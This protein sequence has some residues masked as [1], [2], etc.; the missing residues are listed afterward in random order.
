M[1][2]IIDSCGANIASVQFA[3][4]RLGKQ[5]ILTSD[6]AIIRTADHV[7]LPGVGTAKNAM[8]KLAERDLIT[9]IQKLDQPVLGICLGMQLFY[10]SS[11]EGNVKGLGV[12]PGEI[13]LFP[14]LP[15][16][17]VPH[18]GWNKLTINNNSIL[19]NNIN[20]GDYVYY[21]HSYF[22]PIND[23]TTA[24]TQ[25]GENFTAMVEKDNFYGVQFHPERSG[26]VGEQILKNFLEISG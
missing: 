16:L 3:L 4:E 22:A 24:T 23:N 11:E 17:V 20:T 7:I 12:V 10:Q 21:V 6:S 8:E 25:Y 5:A 19:L 18:M 14:K 2:A 13:K 15:D 9:V 1:I 26:E